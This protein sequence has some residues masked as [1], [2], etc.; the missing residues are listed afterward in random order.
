MTSEVFRERLRGRRE[1]K[2]KACIGREAKNSI[3][4][5]EKGWD[6]IF[7]FA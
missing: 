3:Q 1:K 7:Y 4:K 2:G 5:G 6:I